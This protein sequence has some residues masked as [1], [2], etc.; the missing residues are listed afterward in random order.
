MT[1]PISK[2]AKREELGFGNDLFG[3]PIL[4]RAARFAGEGVRISLSR[5][6]GPG[7]RAFVLGCNPSM[8]DANGDD[9]TSRWW[10]AWFHLFGFG[11][12]DAGNLYPFCTPSP[13]ECRKIV[14]GIDGGDWAARDSLH[15]VNLPAVAEMAKA[16]DQVFVC[17]GNI[18]WDQMW[19]E[20]VVEE[21]QSGPAPCPDLWC[22]G[23]T[24]SGAPTHPMARGKHR[25]PVDQKP[26]LWRA[27]A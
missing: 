27:A 12:Y 19:I 14:D 1:A 10:N 23:A 8:A 26:I 11:G 15:F 20:H 17:F 2:A 16:A 7:P 24:K 18:A 6:W 5:D 3:A 22:W 4:R 13:A 21:I 25:I 9:P